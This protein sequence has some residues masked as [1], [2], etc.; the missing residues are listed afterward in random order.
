[1]AG[2]RPG[3]T[4]STREP[5]FIDFESGSEERSARVSKGEGPIGLM[6]IEAIHRPET[7]LR[8]SSP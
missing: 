3:M 8:G 2:T 6:V 4:N 5:R 7:P 1:M